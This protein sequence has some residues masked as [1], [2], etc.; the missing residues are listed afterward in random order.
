MKISKPAPFNNYG[1]K[2]LI[3]LFI[4]GVLVSQTAVADVRSV[5]QYSQ[6]DVDRLEILIKQIEGQQLTEVE[7]FVVQDINVA[8]EQQII[9]K[10]TREEK[11]LTLK[12]KYLLTKVISAI[13]YRGTSGLVD[14]I[15]PL[16]LLGLSDSRLKDLSEQELGKNEMSILNLFASLVNRDALIPYL[17]N[18]LVM[19]SKI[20]LVGG[21]FIK[22]TASLDLIVQFA[23]S[24]INGLVKTRGLTKDSRNVVYEPWSHI[25][26]RQKAAMKNGQ[27]PTYKVVG[28][29]LASDFSYLVD[30]PA[31]FA[32][33]AEILKAATISI[34]ILVWAIQDDLTGQWIKDLLLQKHRQGVK[35]RII[36]DG[37]VSKR[38]KYGERVAELI[39]E[40]IEVIKWTHPSFQ[41]VGQ[42][43]KMIIA[44]G[45][46]MIAGGLNFGDHYSHLNSKVDFWRDTDIYA[47]GDFV[48]NVALP[49]FDRTWNE[50]A[51]R[52]GVQKIQTRQIGKLAQTK[53]SGVQIELIDH[54]PEKS[55]GQDSNI[56]NSIIADIQ[57]ARSSIDIA[58]AYVIV[59]DAFVQAI[60]DAVDRG[61]RVR[62]LTNSNGSVDEPTLGSAMM[63]S[64]KKLKAIGADVYLR[65]GTT[66][67]SKFMVVDGERSHIMSYNLHP[68][69]ER[70]EGEISFII[71]DRV[72]GQALEKI[73]EADIGS[74][75][76]ATRVKSADEIKLKSDITTWLL[77]RIMYDQ[78]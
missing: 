45:T 27:I 77:I 26:A 18:K 47:A 68:R 36:V 31:S 15:N 43:R 30:G 69:S 54:S 49:F 25:V 76:I 37:D 52:F 13:V 10:P 1:I 58:N 55:Q 46:K 73:F 16:S 40:G 3:S 75:Q 51:S 8:L 56:Y 39:K 48:A 60:K 65:K 44:D 38:P 21:K 11:S 70:M 66:L 22:D 14:K 17:R 72:Q 59:T 74:T 32:K 5:P 41:Y 67:H 57:N 20:P 28:K 23:A 33:R 62:V 64:A 9:N 63:I 42:H 6:N 53:N 34:D 12:E 7:K 78:L 35:V 2:T 19:V 50:A 71:T 61:V 29:A 24:N 4:A